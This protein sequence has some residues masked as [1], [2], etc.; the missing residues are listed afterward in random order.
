MKKFLIFII[1]FVGISFTALSNEMTTKILFKVNKNIITNVD[2]INEANYLK[3][4]NKNLQNIDVKQALLFAENSLI[5]EIIKK[6][7]IEKFYSVNYESSEIDIF[8]NEIINNLGYDNEI[9]FKNYLSEYGIKIEDVKKKLII[10]KT[11]NQLIYERFKDKIK[12][13]KNEIS[14]KLDDL[15][16]NNSYQKS[17]KLS[18][19]VFSEKDKQKFDKKYNEI[20][21]SIKNVGFK[22]TAVIHSISDT[23]R[24]GGEIGWINK[25]QL[26]DKIYSEIKNLKKDEFT[27]PILT[28]GGNII[29]Q[30][31][32][33]KEVLVKEIDKE[34]ELKN[35]IKVERNRQ[36][37]EFSIIYYRKLENK[38][39]VQKL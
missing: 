8:I 7:E 38:S 11:W 35:I 19:I 12:I 18:E 25:N 28:A 3:A 29:L 34:K 14:K 33:I 39:Y 5:R 22:N 16:E 13:D 1:L 37:N 4:L 32:E 31:N 9:E 6:D 27:N 2:I 36:L 21:S 15:L 10:E 23:S 20:L 26:S 30:L 24:N 17:F